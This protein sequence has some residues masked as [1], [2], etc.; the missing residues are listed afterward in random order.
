MTRGL[1]EGWTQFA[2][3]RYKV[4]IT[5]ISEEHVVMP[6]TPMIGMKVIDEL[7][8]YPVYQG[9]LYGQTCSKWVS[10]LC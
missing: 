5:G 6:D 1:G 8:S 3:H 9:S 4:C 2:A 7:M 10:W